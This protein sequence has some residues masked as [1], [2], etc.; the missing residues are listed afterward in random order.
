MNYDITSAPPPRVEQAGILC[1]LAEGC[2]NAGLS[3]VEKGRNNKQ[4]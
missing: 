4:L 2:P 1:M 3:S